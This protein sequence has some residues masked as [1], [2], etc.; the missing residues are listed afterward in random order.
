MKRA[1]SNEVVFL[2]YIKV[3][4]RLFSGNDADIAG[5]DSDPLS[6]LVVTLHD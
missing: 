5:K 6:R 1:I 2:Y 3:V 4:M